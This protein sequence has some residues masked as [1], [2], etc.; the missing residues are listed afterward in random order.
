MELVATQE[1]IEL[2]NG[3][4][5]MLFQIGM[6]TAA[7]ALPS[8]CHLTG[9]PVKVLLPMHWPVIAAGLFCGWRAGLLAGAASP[10]ISFAISGMPPAGYLPLMTMELAVYGFTA[11]FAIERLRLKPV[12]AVLLSVLAGRAALVAATAAF[13]PLAV[14]LWAYI[15]SAIVPGL[16]AAFG[17]V[18][19]LPLVSG[20]YSGKP[21]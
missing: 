14:G 4:K 3:S 17:Q 7:V 20:K 9:M 15:L 1:R 8:V 11:G 6:V 10:L 2:V 12:M 16:P 13:Y 21:V 5:G 18:A 19:L